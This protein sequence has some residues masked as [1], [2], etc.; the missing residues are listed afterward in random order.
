MPS[1]AIGGMFFVRLA[2]PAM[3]HGVKISTRAVRISMIECQIRG[4]SDAIGKLTTI[5]Q[6]FTNLE[7]LFGVLAQFWGRMGNVAT[8]LKDANDVTAL[9]IGEGILSDISSI[10]SSVETNKKMIDACQKYLDVL[11]GQGITIIASSDTPSNALRNPR[12]IVA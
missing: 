8:S 9:L 5:V 7:D 12:T 1:M 4:V 6:K 10:Q 2:A 11:N 3:I